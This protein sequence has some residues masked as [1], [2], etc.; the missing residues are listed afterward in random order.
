MA[1]KKSA[2]K[3]AKKSAKKP[4]KKSGRRT[5]EMMLEAIQALRDNPDKYRSLQKAL[6]KSKSDKERVKQL[7]QYATSDR[8][9]AAL[10]PARVAG[11]GEQQLMWTTVT[12]TTIFILEGSAY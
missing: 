4:A 3:A 1:T 12:V 2:K 8:E 5:E 11:G 10:L 7:L 6:K 9:L